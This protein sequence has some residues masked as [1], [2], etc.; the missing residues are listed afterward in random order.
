MRYL[1]KVPWPLGLMLVFGLFQGAWAAELDRDEV[2]RLNRKVLDKVKPALLLV[3]VTLKTT[4][5]PAGFGTGFLVSAD[6]KV[7]T[8][9]HVVAGT[10]FEPDTY[11]LGYL[12]SDGSREAWKSSPWMWRTTS[13]CCN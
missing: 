10:V 2:S 1:R 6:G 5:T 11:T 9:Y 7:V 8:N 13:R 12:R 4:Q 3:E